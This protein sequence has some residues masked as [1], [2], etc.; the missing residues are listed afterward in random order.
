MEALVYYNGSYSTWSEA[1]IPISDR[2]I[3]FGDAVYD[4]ILGSKK[5]GLYQIDEH[6]QRLTENAQRIGI[7]IPT[8]LIHTAS[9]LSA[10]AACDVFSLYIQLSRAS[11]ERRHDPDVNSRVNTL[12]LL[13]EAE[14]PAADAEYTA[15]TAE[16]VRY[17]MCDVKT[18]NL[19]PAVLASANAVSAGADE[20]IF[21]RGG[22]VTEGAKTNLFIIKDNIL[23]THPLGRYILPGI[24]RANVIKKCAAQGIPV[25]EIPF[26]LREMM[27]ADEI[28]LTSTTKFT[29][30]ISEIDGASVGGKARELAVR[31]GMLLR[32]DFIC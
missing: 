9:C 17:A 13:S 4:V 27:S 11:C 26:T 12:M 10:L 7:S 20:A 19:L 6:L 2:S 24:M 21:V 18:T 23:L 5:G 29:K 14:V 16:D 25:R 31:L 1:K 28:F 8:G 15:I 32:K 30:I 3:F 22:V